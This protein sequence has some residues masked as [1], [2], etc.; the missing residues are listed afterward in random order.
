MVTAA[1][2][3]PRG[4]LSLLLLGRTNKVSLPASPPGRTN[5]VS[6]TT[7]GC[8]GLAT[9]CSER[10]GIGRGAAEQASSRETYFSPKMAA[11]FE[12]LINRLAMFRQ[13]KKLEN[14]KLILIWLHYEAM[15]TAWAELGVE[16]PATCSTCQPPLPSPLV[17]RNAAESAHQLS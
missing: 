8:H 7:G 13:Q 10:P 3:S 4:T 2:S 12:Q 15:R 17:V 5:K 11:T 6:S 16:T 9:V 1:A 14:A